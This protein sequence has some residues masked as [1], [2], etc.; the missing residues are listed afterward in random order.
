M[1]HMDKGGKEL[2]SELLCQD[3]L[4]PKKSENCGSIRVS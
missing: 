2:N 3:L 4:E 1:I